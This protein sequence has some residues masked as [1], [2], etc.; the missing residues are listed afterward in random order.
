MRKGFWKGL[1]AIELFFVLAVICMLVLVIY[2]RYDSFACQ[3]M[4]SE[5]KFSLQQIYSAQKY[6]F[7]EHDRF[8][9]LKQLSVDKSRVVLTEKYYTFSDLVPPGHDSFMIIAKGRKNS[10]VEGEEWI[11]DQGRDIKS[12]NIDC[13]IGRASCRERE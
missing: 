7:E 11:I 13:K 2:S 6:Y 10:L 1:R 12:R 5:A 3:S 4:H 8:A 9:S